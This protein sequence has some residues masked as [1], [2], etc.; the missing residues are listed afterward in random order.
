MDL[1]I[2][3][4]TEMGGGNYC[5]AGWDITAKRM[6]R[7]LPSGSNWPAALLGGHGIVA[8]TLVRIEPQGASNGAYPHRTEDTA[9]NPAAIATSNG[10]FSDWLGASAPHVAAD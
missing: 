9:I 8:G 6:I 4:V 2:T 10:I 3:E 5:V 1:L 7:P